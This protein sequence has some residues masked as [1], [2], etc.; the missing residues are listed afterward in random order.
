M[1]SEKVSD[2]KS[3]N[4]YNAGMINFNTAVASREICSLVMWGTAR[5][6][7]LLSEEAV[8]CSHCF[9]SRG[10]SESSGR[11]KNPLLILRNFTENC[12]IVEMKLSIDIQV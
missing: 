11:Q 1:Q 12:P 9:D 7:H 5:E 10:T 4:L 6:I 8:D 2:K 3:R